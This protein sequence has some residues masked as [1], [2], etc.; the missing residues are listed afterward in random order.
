M[1][2]FYKAHRKPPVCARCVSKAMRE[3]PKNADRRFARMVAEEIVAIL[4]ERGFEIHSEP[5][6]G[7]PPFTPTA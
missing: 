1:C 2:E 3:K 7:S 6:G 5:T 4:D